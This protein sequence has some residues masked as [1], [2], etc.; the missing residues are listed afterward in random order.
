M[1]WN[2]SAVDTPDSWVGT[3]GVIYVPAVGN[4]R[5]ITAVGAGFTGVLRCTYTPSGL[6]TFLTRDSFPITHHAA[7]R[8]QLPDAFDSADVPAPL[9]S[10]QLHTEAPAS[11]LI[12]FLSDPGGMRTFQLVPVVLGMLASDQVLANTVL[13]FALT[14]AHGSILMKD[15]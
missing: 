10:L 5:T 11:S 14:L 12:P 7:A 1:W 4:D 2:L 9:V 3:D 13:P 6:P 8:C 15:R